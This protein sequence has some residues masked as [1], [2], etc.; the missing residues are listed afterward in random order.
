MIV[1]VNYA[2]DLTEVGGA[3][4]VVARIDK[5]VSKRLIFLIVATYITGLASCRHASVMY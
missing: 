2:A 5:L 3:A 4:R 1:Q